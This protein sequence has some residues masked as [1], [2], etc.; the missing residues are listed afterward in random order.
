[1]QW[2]FRV[3]RGRVE[4]ELLAAAESTDLIAVGKSVQALSR[5]VRMGRTARAVA[6][7]NHCS[8]LFVAPGD[9]VRD[10]TIAALYDGTEATTR[11][12][13]MAAQLAGREGGK[14]VVLVLADAGTD[15]VVRE[16]RAVELVR[17][18]GIAAAIRPAGDLLR[19]LK[20]EN[21]GLVVL[22]S[23]LVAGADE[24]LLTALVE[25]S[26]SSILLTRC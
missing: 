7:Q 20:A 15:P 4:A 13:A 19:T 23:V 12:L 6:Q 22:P 21:I 26:D 17:D 10:R 5:S 3:V 16:R 9:A 14:L 18:L 1:L 11:S 25:Q 24:T 8:I 2:T